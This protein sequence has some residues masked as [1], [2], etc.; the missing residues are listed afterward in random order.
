MGRNNLLALF[1]QI[2]LS[3]LLFGILAISKSHPA[4]QSQI[5][6]GGGRFLLVAFI[7]FYYWLL[8]KLLGVSTWWMSLFSTIALPLLGG[9]FLAISYLAEGP[10][11]FPHGGGAS[12]WRFP[13][14]VLMLPESLV[15]GLF[16][17]GMSLRTLVLMPL[18][19]WLFLTLGTGI[20]HLR[21]IRRARRRRRQ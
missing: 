4:W 6:H 19:P 5:L 14:D 18:A 12:L 10:G 11:V 8:T 9:C 7:F 13:Y 2:L 16:R 1:G 17:Q 15:L 21:R 20:V 3:L